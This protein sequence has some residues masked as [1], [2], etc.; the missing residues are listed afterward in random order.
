MD[1]EKKNLTVSFVNFANMP[2]TIVN[3][4]ICDVLYIVFIGFHCLGIRRL[5]G[6]NCK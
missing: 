3:C 2:G 1:G 5:S 4:V 6:Y